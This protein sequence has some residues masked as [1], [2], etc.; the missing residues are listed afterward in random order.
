MSKEK[1]LAEIK[2]ELM[3]KIQMLTFDNYETKR[4]EMNRFFDLIKELDELPFETAY[5][6]SEKIIRFPGE[7][8]ETPKDELSESQSTVEKTENTS[9]SEVGNVYR[10]ER[11]LRGGIVPD[12]DGGYLIPEKMVRDMDAEDGDLLRVVSEHQGYGQ[13]YFNFEIDKK[14]PGPNPNRVEHR[15]C[16]V[17]KEAGYLVVKESQGETIRVDEVPFTFVLKD[18]DIHHFKLDVGDIVDIAYYK[19]NPSGTVRVIFKYDTDETVE[20]TIE[21]KKLNFDDQKEKKKEEVKE[22]GGTKYPIEYELFE[23]K[24]V[25]IIG[26]EN[27]HSDY[28]NAFEKLGIELET[29][30]GMEGEKRLEA[31]IKR[32]D[33]AVLVIG[34]L[35]HAASSLAVKLCKEHH[36]PFDA[37]YDKGIQSVLLCAENAIKKGIEQGIVDIQETA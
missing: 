17:V 23:G 28:R 36:I 34:E 6:Q 5:L 33:I 27:R 22:P 21:K 29:L 25:L 31:A 32:S 10:F 2:N 7:N 18:K 35:R 15:Y 13:K 9:G 3:T 16:K 14:G 4:A 1:I 8:E 11:K 24:R 26:G 12:L 20:P 30:D 19:S 37:T